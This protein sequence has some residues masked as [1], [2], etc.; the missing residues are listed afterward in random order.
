MFVAGHRVDGR[1]RRPEADDVEHGEEQPARVKNGV[2]RQ[3][4]KLRAEVDQFVDLG[5]AWQVDFVG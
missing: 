2:A 4:L 5:P 1:R 3:K